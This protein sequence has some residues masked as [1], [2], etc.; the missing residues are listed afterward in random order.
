MLVLRGGI[1][2]KSVCART[3]RGEGDLKSERKHFMD[4]RLC[5]DFKTKVTTSLKHD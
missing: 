3:W 1:Q 4:H 5:T 2:A